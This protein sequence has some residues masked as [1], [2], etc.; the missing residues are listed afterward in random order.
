MD[1]SGGMKVTHTFLKHLEHIDA[2]SI[3]ALHGVAD[4]PGVNFSDSGDF[5]YASSFPQVSVLWH[6]KDSSLTHGFQPILMGASFDDA[7]I[8]A[9]ATVVSTEGRAF[10]NANRSGLDFWTP[11]INPFKDPRWGRGQVSTRYI[12][13]IIVPIAEG[14]TQP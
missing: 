11:N 6:L 9:V 8:E 3:T 10:N 12:M 13:R 7:L 5:S 1:L 4:S 14:L 2:H